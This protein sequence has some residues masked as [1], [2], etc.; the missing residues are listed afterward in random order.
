MSLI[1]EFKA[2]PCYQTRMAVVGACIR[3]E[4]LFSVAFAPRYFEIYFDYEGSRVVVH[5][6]DSLDGYPD[7]AVLFQQLGVVLRQFNQKQIANIEY[8]D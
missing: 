5:R 3:K 6:T 4:I 8:L 7:A 2:N 1:A